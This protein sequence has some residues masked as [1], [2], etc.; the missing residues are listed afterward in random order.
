MKLKGSVPFYPINASKCSPSE[1][2]VFL[3]M[4]ASIT[5]DYQYILLFGIR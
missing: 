5:Y 3:P 2:D 4:R 1:M